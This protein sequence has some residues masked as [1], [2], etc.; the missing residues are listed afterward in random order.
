MTISGVG[1][2]PGHSYLVTLNETASFSFAYGCQYPGSLIGPDT[3][4]WGY[5]LDI[6]VE[7]T[8]KYF[9]CFRQDADEE[10]KAI[11]STE[12]DKFLAKMLMN[13]NSRFNDD[14]S[15][16]LLSILRPK[17]Y[18]V[19]LTNTLTKRQLRM[20]YRDVAII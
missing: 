15:S 9:V 16:A 18:D 1:F 14:Q 2:V 8:G 3:A 5:D 4:Q 7:E 19:N 13:N 10:F 11:P 12:G 6:A 17:S 20:I